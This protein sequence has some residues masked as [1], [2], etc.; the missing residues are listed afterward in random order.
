VK[1]KK[2][3]LPPKRKNREPKDHPTAREETTMK[4]TVTDLISRLLEPLALS[5]LVLRGK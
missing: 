1:T 5:A 2:R 4:H 3:T